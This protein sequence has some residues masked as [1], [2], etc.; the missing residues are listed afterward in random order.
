MKGSGTC[1]C[2]CARQCILCIVSL[3][4]ADMSVGGIDKVKY[5][6]HQIY[7]LI[8]QSVAKVLEKWKSNRCPALK[9]KFQIPIFRFWSNNQKSELVTGY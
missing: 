6:M 8:P 5:Y 7:Y 9:S 1:C 4:L 2:M 3:K